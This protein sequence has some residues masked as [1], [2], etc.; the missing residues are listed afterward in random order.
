M[1]PLKNVSQ[2]LVAIDV[3]TVDRTRAMPVHLYC[4]PSPSKGVRQCIVFD[5]DKQDAR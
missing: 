5:S 1:N 2:H 4:G 3:D